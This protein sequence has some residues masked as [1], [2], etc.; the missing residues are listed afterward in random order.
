MAWRY[1]NFMHML[2]FSVFGFV[3]LVQR[4]TVQYRVHASE[5]L[6]YSIYDSRSQTVNWL[7]R[8][9][10]TRDTRLG[11]DARDVFQFA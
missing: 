9:G 2:R 6:L 10:K 3:L 4:Y 1:I 11:F 5:I 8:D 7:M